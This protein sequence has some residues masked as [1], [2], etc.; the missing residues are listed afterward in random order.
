MR[1]QVRLSEVFSRKERK[2][3]VHIVR[4]KDK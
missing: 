3:L 2:M 1:F 4:M